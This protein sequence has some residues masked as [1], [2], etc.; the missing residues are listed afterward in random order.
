M[1]NY[2]TSQHFE[3]TWTAPKTIPWNVDNTSSLSH[4]WVLLVTF[5]IDGIK[6]GGVSSTTG[7]FFQRLENSCRSFPGS[8]F[9]FSLFSKLIHH[10]Q[11]NRNSSSS[12]SIMSSTISIVS[13]L[14]L[15]SE[16]FDAWVLE[17]YEPNFR[18]HIFFVSQL[19]L[20]FLLR[21]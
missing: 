1:C 13:L 7:F 14:P 17:F 12:S 6:L 18:T 15:K 5:R 4:N 10:K 9:M 3:S 11:G 2:K 20:Q 8:T 19:L 21:C 16:I